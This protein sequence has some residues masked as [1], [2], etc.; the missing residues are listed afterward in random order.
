MMGGA[1]YASGAL[2][3]AYEAVSRIARLRGCAT[4]IAAALVVF[5]VQISPALGASTGD[6]AEEFLWGI[7]KNGNT[8]AL[9]KIYLQDYPNGL[10]SAEAEARIKEL[11]APSA[12]PAQEQSLAQPPPIPAPAPPPKA[13]PQLSPAPPPTPEQQAK[14]IQATFYAK[15]KA[16]LREAPAGDGKIR[17]HL[18]LREVLKVDLQSENGQWYHVGGA[19][20]GWVDAGHTMDAKTAEAEAWTQAD[21]TSGV[22]GLQAYLKEFSKGAHAK[23]AQ[24]KLDAV[25]AEQAP[26]G[27]SQDHQ[28]EGQG[29]TPEER[30]ALNDLTKSWRDEPAPEDPRQ[31]TPPGD[32]AGGMPPHPDAP[33]PSPEPNGTSQ[34]ASREPDQR[35][36]LPTPTLPSGNAMEQYDAALGM[37]IHGQFKDGEERLESII[38]QFPSDPIIANVRYSL[39][40][41][42]FNQQDYEHALIQLQLALNLKPSSP[43]APLA[44]LQIAVSKGYR[45]EQQ[46]ACAE[47]QSLSS[48]YRGAVLDWEQRISEWQRNLQCGR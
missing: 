14:R 15:A 17:R 43:T 30:E 28:A 18:R 13:P 25:E 44:H 26:P 32:N 48:K 11:S 42:Y 31:I 46:E 3:S 22:E 24:E 12:Q 29:A 41:S 20:G 27:T 4:A 35:S 16:V 9:F 8:E 40:D 37:L 23:E 2:T 1:R 33:I 47:L 21:H 10:H 39:G 45:G 6:P 34:E 19:H 36:Q 38:R 7:A 5:S